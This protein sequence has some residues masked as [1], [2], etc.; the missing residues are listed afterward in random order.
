MTFGDLT[1][2]KLCMCEKRREIV[3][4][5]NNHLICHGGGLLYECT[6]PSCQNLPASVDIADLLLSVSIHMTQRHEF[7]VRN[8][9]FANF[10]LVF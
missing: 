5:A 10:F 8:L 3:Y 7:C 6:L 2:V 1:R 4:I 9:L